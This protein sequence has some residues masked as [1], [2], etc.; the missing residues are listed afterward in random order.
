MNNIIN[1]LIVGLGGFIGAIFR[2]FGSGI[3]Q[4]L[5]KNYNFPYGTLFVNLLGCF[6]IGFLGGCSDNMDIFSSKTRLFLF[7]GV[8][9]GF[10][11]FSSFGYETIMLLR[12]RLISAA[13]I[14]ISIHFILGLFFVYFGY[15][16]SMR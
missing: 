9:G 5:F 16:L 15:S 14:N 4:N 11:T 3:F 7:I 8:I 6:I 12:D 2:Y 1:I 10:T 13:L